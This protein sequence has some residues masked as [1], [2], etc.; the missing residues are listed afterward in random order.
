MSV[1]VELWPGRWE[2]AD[3]VADG[4]IALDAAMTARRRCRGAC[5]RVMPYCV[6]PSTDRRCWD[7]FTKEGNS[8]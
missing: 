8:E 1:S 7:C 3:R 2:V 5:G 6:P 4:R